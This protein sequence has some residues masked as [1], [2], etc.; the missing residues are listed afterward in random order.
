MKM[1]MVER[2]FTVIILFGFYVVGKSEIYIV[3]IEGEPVTSYRG[4]VS[5]FEA[6]AVE[7]DEKLDV[8]SDSVSS[9]SQH[10]ELKHDTLL[11]TLFDQGTYT[12]LYSYK[13]LINGFAVDISPEQ[14]K[15]LI[16][17][18]FLPTF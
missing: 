18:I 3:T 1:M 8:T 4:G 9:Y 7:S 14:V 15:P 17:L 16:F 10:L 5:G 6:T 13:H 11:E 12:K 2:M